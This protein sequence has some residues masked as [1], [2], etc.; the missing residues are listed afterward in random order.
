MQASP[1]RVAGIGSEQIISQ[2]G[3]RPRDHTRIESKQE[4]PDA[5]DAGQEA[6]LQADA[7][8][9]MGRRWA[10]RRK[11]D[12]V[13]E[14]QGHVRLWSGQDVCKADAWQ[15]HG[16][17]QKEVR[18]WRASVRATND[19][20]SGLLTWQCRQLPQRLCRQRCPVAPCWAASSRPRPPPAYLSDPES[21]CALAPS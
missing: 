16:H 5:A 17:R 9:G 3:Q 21:L 19:A 8:P 14:S 4:A 7:F 1:R 15:A 11:A 20:L 10:S 13:R 2:V 12:S 18:L 6:Q